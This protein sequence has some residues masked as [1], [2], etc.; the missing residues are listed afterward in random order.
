MPRRWRRSRRSRTRNC[1]GCMARSPSASAAARPVS[2]RRH[3]ACRTCRTSLSTASNLDPN[4]VLPDAPWA[5]SARL[6]PRTGSPQADLAAFL[7]RV[8]RAQTLAI[9][10]SQTREAEGLD[11]GSDHIARLWANDRV[12]DLM[13]T[14]PADNR[15]AAVSLATQYRLVTPVSG[16][17]VLETKQQYDESRL[18]ACE[19]GHGADRS[20]TA[21]VG[22]AAHGL[23]CACCGSSGAIGSDPWRWHDAPA[24]RPRAGRHGDLGRLALVLQAGSGC[25]GGSGGAR[26]D[27]RV[28]RPRRHI[29]P[30]AAATTAAVAARFRSHVLLAVF[31]A[32]HAVLPPIVRAAAALALT[33]FCL[34]VAMFKERPPVAFWGLVALA[35]AGAAVAAVHARLSD[36]R[37]LRRAHGRH[38]CKHMALRSRGRE[39]FSPGAMS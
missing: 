27:G 31:A 20:R 13:R 28:S 22:L 2:S 8:D 4:E 16:A 35:L 10:R 24:A 30:V 37:R 5:W 21:R 23:R 29:P 17:V 34:H 12:L 3:R 14:N 36:A 7:A 39:H 26:A 19:P 15:A 25:T 11:K 6:L 38:C 1:S 33:L 9:H 18:D 32:T